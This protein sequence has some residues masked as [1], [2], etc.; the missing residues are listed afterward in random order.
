MSCRTT[1][2][3][4]D[5]VVWCRT[6]QQG[7]QPCGGVQDRMVWCRTIWFD[8]GPYKTVRTSSCPGELGSRYPESTRADVCLGAE[9]DLVLPTSTQPVLMGTRPWGR[10]RCPGQDPSSQD[11]T[12]SP[13]L[14]IFPFPGITLGSIIPPVLPQHLL[15]LLLGEPWGQSRNRNT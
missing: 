7:V 11:H 15:P 8:V 1:E 14:L 6:I 13:L 12:P 3:V 4:Q 2:G 9:N 5:D 10:R